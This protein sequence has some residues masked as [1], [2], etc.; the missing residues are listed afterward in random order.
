[1]LQYTFGI[2]N[3][4]QNSIDPIDVKT[5]KLLTIHKVFYKLQCH[6]RLYLP[7]SKGG[8][9]LMNINNTHRGTTVSMARYIATSI[10]LHIKEI[11]NMSKTNQIA[12]HYQS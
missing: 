8:M 10:Q 5:R 7:R 1:M 4:P 11:A 2:I 6:A 3:W 12:F 9:V